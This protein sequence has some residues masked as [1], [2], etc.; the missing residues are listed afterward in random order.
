MV[1]VGGHPLC[2]HC[3]QLD[4]VDIGIGA[5]EEVQTGFKIYRNRGCNRDQILLEL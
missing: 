1:P 5:A 3:G 4:G 2:S